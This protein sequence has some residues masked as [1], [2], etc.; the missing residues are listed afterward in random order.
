[1]TTNRTLAL[2][3][4]LTVTSALGFAIA[5]QTA[6]AQAAPANSTTTTTT[7]TTTTVA[8]PETAE[9]AMVLS[10]FVVDASEDSASYKANSTL[11]GTRVRTDLKDVPSAL[12]VVTA[13]FLQDTGATRAEDLL[14]YTPN[15]E[16]TGLRGNFA[17]QGTNAIYN[18]N[19]L[20]ATTRV[21]GL[22]SADNTRNYFLTDI[23]WDVFNVGRVDLL[24]GPNSILFGVGSP[25]GI[26][27]TSTN[28][29][30]FTTQYKAENRI[31]NWGSIRDSLDFNQVL[32]PDVLSVRVDVV[33]DDSLYEQSPAFNDTDRAYAAI[34]FDPK[35]FG[36]RNHT[37]I[38]ANVEQG[39]VNSNDPR[40]IPPDDQITP[41]FQTGTD[42]YGNPGLNKLIVNQ[43]N[44]NQSS[45]AI[46]GLTLPGYALAQVALQGNFQTRS[47]NWG[48]IINYYETVQPGSNNVPNALPPSGD[49]I[50]SVSARVN[51]GNAPEVSNGN[52]GNYSI[53][54]GGGG[55][56]L[57]LFVP[58]GISPYNSYA[59]YVGTSGVRQEY[60]N[61]NYQY[62]GNPIPGGGY[63]SDKVITDPSIFN[64]Y[65]YLLDGPNKSEWQRWKAMNV[66][67]DQSFLDDRFSFEVAFD[68]QDYTGGQFNSLGGPQYAISVDVNATYANGVANP[69]A[70]RPYVGDADGAPNGG[71]TQSETVRNTFRFT[72]VID[73]RASDLFGN[74]TLAKIL[75]H[76]VFTGLFDQNSAK[77]SNVSWSEYATTPDYTLQNSADSIASGVPLSLD[78]LDSSREFNWLAYIGP[79]LSNRSSASGANLQNINYVIAPPKN[80]LAWN[81]NSTWNAPSTV[82]QLDP[83]TYT[84]SNTGNPVVGTQL[85]NPA[86][87]VG[88][89][90]EPITYLDAHNP[91]DFPNL[92][93]QASRNEYRDISK[94]L[95]YQGY[96]LG[97]DLVP[98][99]GWRK[100]QVTNYQ[101]QAPTDTSSGEA[102][103]SLYYPTNY[104]SRS[105]ARGESKT[106]GGVYHLS[107]ALTKYLPWDTT[108]SL[109][110]DRSSNFKAD[111]SR[112]DF[113]GNP[114]PNANGV[115]KEYGFVITTLS[116]KLSLKVNWYDTVVNN[117]QLAGTNANVIGGIAPNGFFVGQGVA[118]GYEWATSLQDGYEGKTPQNT[119]YDYAGATYGYANNSPQDVAANAVLDP[120]IINAWL[121]EIKLWPSNYFTSYDQ[122][123]AI[124][125][126][127]AIATGQLASGYL[128][129]AN[130]STGPNI[131]GGSSFG[132]HVS[133]VNDESKGVEV[134]LTTQLQ[135]N[136]NLTLNYSKTKA[137][138]ESFNAG[139]EEFISQVTGFMNGPGGQ[140]R[141]WYNGG[142]TLG[143]SWNSNIVAPFTVLLNNLGHETPD[144]APWKLNL[145]TTY[146][147]DRGWAEGLFVGG[148]YRI[149]GGR[150][151]GYRYDPNF[152]NVNST[153]PNY[154]A[155]ALVTQGGL[156]VNEPLIGPDD[157]HV[158]MW[159]GYTRK[160][161]KK[162]NWRIQLNLQNVG[163][164][165]SLV[166]AKY[167]PDGSLALATI[168][169]GMGWQLTNAFDF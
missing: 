147:F 68:H 77:T 136:W 4:A 8:A 121:Q 42:A 9:P 21:R 31:D 152:K 40:S 90:Q 126:N 95:T 83:Y 24:R 130:D 36:D 124:N 11:A 15:T 18:E 167:E 140:V 164:K 122:S 60:A 123:P 145:V 38:R 50:Y 13:Q 156:N 47:A 91:A 153:D 52:G 2:I 142:P 64:F 162:I 138:V 23:P 93:N 110:Y 56:P 69:N 66:A 57:S 76:S 105:D 75:G 1:M 35:L 106:W 71:G 20:S 143:S 132:N 63:Y 30:G 154:A 107:K 133:T 74:T 111:P 61:A 161:T 86:N 98:T 81:F 29:A 14:V 114:V 160:I 16:V 87:Y 103:T 84:S 70:G 118:W 3:R 48:D 116:D 96:F 155:V 141:M 94:G 134:E 101:T 43:Y 10:P 127:L 45:P 39:K 54:Q 62:P 112:L 115:T 41:W 34:R 26:I 37:E 92:V 151:L 169:E 131:T 17:G 82:N 97:G 55:G 158:D 100:D 149:E 120:P 113:E 59:N 53:L 22:D 5:P 80:E 144:L 163:E 44:T 88:W 33:K 135:R 7:T 6:V 166:P 104:A 79:N 73:L 19:T 27:N 125:P 58:F 78:G 109:L 72:P 89:T 32:I 108:I 117:D 137:V 150:I 85:D 129:G 148:G 159:I 168:Q 128:Q 99:L 28:D 165:D 12:S 102:F 139:E 157:K 65:K 46:P 146:R 49:P 67:I 51:T 119:Y 25:A